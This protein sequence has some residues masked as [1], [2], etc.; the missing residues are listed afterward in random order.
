MP[1]NLFSRYIWIV[2]TIKRYGR[3]TR[4]ELNSLW[5]KSSYSNGEPLARRTFY[6]YR[7]AIEDLFKISIEC[8][9]STFEYYINDDDTH[10]QS[11]TDWLLNSATMSD[12]LNDAR[13]VSSRIFLEDI[14][15]AR[16]HLSNVIKALKDSKPLRFTYQPFTRVNATP[17]IVV[18]PYF[19]KIFRQRW[20]V[21]GHNP[22]DGRI[23]T[24]ALDRIRELTVMNETFELPADFDPEAFTRDSFGIVFSMGEVKTVVLK[25]DARQAKYLR[26]LPLHHSQSEMLHDA[27]SMFHYRLK[28][29]PDFVEEILKHGPRLTVVSPPEL[30]AMVTSELRAAL[31]NYN[32]E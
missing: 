18:H 25:C 32:A 29:T 5:V 20:Y 9:P 31:D 27:Y 30:R 4:E 22:A 23:K 14:P 2:D 6:N 10:S 16:I 15:S 12:V 28:L 26:A 21:T 3:I 13:D 17:G 24:Y 11:V 19:L 8:D 1:K 7:N